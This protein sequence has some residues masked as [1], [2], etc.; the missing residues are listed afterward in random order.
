MNERQEHPNRLPRLGLRVFPGF[1]DDDKTVQR[2]VGLVGGIGTI[3]VGVANLFI[4]RDINSVDLIVS[5]NS[6]HTGLILLLGL[7]SIGCG[8]WDH[9]I[10]R[11]GHVGLFVF[12]G[13]FGAV[14][15]NRGNITSAFFLVLAIILLVEYRFKRKTAWVLASLM[16]AG[17]VAAL[18]IGYQDDG[19]RP[20]VSAFV[21]LIT[22]L[23]FVGLFG[24]VILRH[25]IRL[26]RNAASL[27]ERIVERTADLNKA[28]SERTVM[29]QEIHHRVKN[30]MQTVSALLGMEVDKMPDTAAKGALTASQQ[31]IQA[32][33]SVHDVLYRS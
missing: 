30:N 4:Y 32:M 33:A 26:Q 12:A 28:L 5:F 8:F 21:S 19:P 23:T 24:G 14:D 18:S 3:L 27:E 10:A 13:I 1:A 6:S 31:R 22:V 25:R 15:A 9:D 7:I 2:L 17:Y 16:L 11:G 29:L 20:V